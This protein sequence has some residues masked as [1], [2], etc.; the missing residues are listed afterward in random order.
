M[1][2]CVMFVLHGANSTTLRYS[3]S[4]V[5]NLHFGNFFFLFFSFLLLSPEIPS[6]VT[7]DDE[8]SVLRA[9][10]ARFYLRLL[11]TKPL[12]YIL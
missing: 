5:Q 6:Y 7:C 4:I 8:N 1:F 9:S 11:F 2:P 12:V 3:P 10:L